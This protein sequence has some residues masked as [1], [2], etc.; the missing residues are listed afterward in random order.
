[1]SDYALKVAE[2]EPL[3]EETIFAQALTQYAAALFH[4]EGGSKEQFL[5]WCE[6]CWVLANAPGEIPPTN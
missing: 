5:F 4:L 3:G 6:I 2:A 1:M